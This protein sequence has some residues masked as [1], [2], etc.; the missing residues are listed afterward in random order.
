MVE[1]LGVNKKHKPTIE[2]GFLY[3]PVLIYATTVW[4]QIDIL[5]FI[6]LIP[7]IRFAI[8][9]K[10]PKAV[11]LFACALLTK[12]TILVFAPIFG[13]Y[14][15][16]KSGIL[17]SVY[18]AIF[19][20]I[21]IWAGYAPFS[22][23]ANVLEPIVLY[24]TKVQFA[25]ATT[26]ATSSAMNMWVLFS[27]FKTIH[28]TTPMFLG[29]T[30][31]T[32]GLVITAFLYAFIAYRMYLAQKPTKQVGMKLFWPSLLAASFTAFLFLTR[33]HNRHLVAALPFTAIMIESDS[34]WKKIYFITSALI[35]LNLLYT[36]FPGRGDLADIIPWFVI[37]LGAVVTLGMYVFILIKLSRSSSQNSNLRVS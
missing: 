12:Q 14:I 21:L 10:L 23:G 24:L 4:G 6:F 30:Y 7:A 29:I 15:F 9:N 27:P 11:F 18:L 13:I 5:P 32:A 2:M 16:F 25:S 33:L 37:V 22:T 3:N 28:D 8:H 31:R 35:G 1:E 36:W 26:Y 20:V 17:R 34:S 19:G